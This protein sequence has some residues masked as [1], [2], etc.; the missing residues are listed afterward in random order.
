MV[1]TG[2]IFAALAFVG[3]ARWEEHDYSAGSSG[4]IAGSIKSKL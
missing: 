1:K 4:E 3:L 2:F